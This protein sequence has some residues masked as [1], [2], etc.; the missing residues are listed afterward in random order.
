VRQVAIQQVR[1]G[2]ADPLVIARGR[3]MPVGVIQPAIDVAVAAGLLEAG[4]DGLT[5]TRRGVERFRGVVEAFIGWLTG[6]V[7]DVG[8]A[9]LDDAGRAELRTLARRLAVSAG[10][11][12]GDPVELARAGLA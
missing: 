3:H 11:P 2:F 9:P 5:L 6:Q 8:G 4:A 10:P 12:V 1:G 7:E